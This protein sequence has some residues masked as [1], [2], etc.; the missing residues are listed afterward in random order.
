MGCDC[1]AQAWSEAAIYG[2]GIEFR[3]VDFY[4]KTREI[5]ASG[6]TLADHLEAFLKG[7][8]RMAGF[9]RPIATA[10][11]RVALSHALACELGLA[12]VDHCT[13][14]DDDDV[15]ALA[16][17]DTV[18]TLLPG[19]EFVSNAEPEEPLPDGAPL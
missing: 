9:G 1:A 4:N 11:E 13:Y 2:R 10:D 12:A 7:G 19:V 6:V 17:G 18:A 14:L 8:G 5:L 16:A 15:A 3:A